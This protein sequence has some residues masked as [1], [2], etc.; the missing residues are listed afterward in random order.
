MAANH[1]LVIADAD[2]CPFCGS[3]KMFLKACS[4]GVGEKRFAVSIQCSKCHVNG[5]QV[6][7]E[8]SRNLGYFNNLDDSVKDDLIKRA[9]AK[10]NTRFQ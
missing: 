10:W 2:V 6:F 8:W 4:E 1:R 9:L 5:P 3:N 7:G